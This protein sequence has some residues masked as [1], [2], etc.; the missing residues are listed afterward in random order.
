MSKDIDLKAIKPML[1]KSWQK[2][3]AHLS[4]I[5]II[6]VLLAYVF[7]VFNISKL[8]TA[9]PSPEDQDLA[10]TATNIPK[11]NKKAIEQIQSLEQTNTQIHSLFDQARNNPFQE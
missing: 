5:V 8:A 7:M 9:E 4:F 3:S 10:I 1:K 2:V 11:V 6:V